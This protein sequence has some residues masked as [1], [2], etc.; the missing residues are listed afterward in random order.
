ML[1]LHYHPLSS[2]CHKV[3]VALYENGTPFTPRLVDLGDPAQAAALRALWPMR[4]FPVLEDAAR[5]QVVAESTPIIEYLDL[6]YAGHAS[7]V[8]SHPEMAFEARRWD[9]FFDLYVHDPM[10]KI[11]GDRLRPEGQQDAFGVARSRETLA[12]AYGV[13][14]AHIAGKEWAIG[15]AF[16]LADC[17]ASPALYYANLVQAIE[18]PHLLAYCARLQARPSYARTLEEARPYFHM[19]PR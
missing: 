15:D 9:R 12:T 6:H 17:A 7:L 14:E 5:G 8:P 11:V 1:T 10:Q 3:L 13:I 2:Y 19:F 16:T 18:Q 4:K